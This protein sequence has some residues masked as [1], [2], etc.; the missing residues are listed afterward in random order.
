MPP[1]GY[2]F[3]M[4]DHATITPYPDGPLIVRGPF[5]ITDEHG[6]PIDAGRRTVALCR[7]GRSQLRP[8]C[9]GSHLTARFRAEGG[10]SPRAAQRHLLD[11]SDYG[12]R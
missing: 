6:T 11:D 12:D 3:V 10:V 1:A 5:Q 8:F 7:C 2:L 9:D 4:T